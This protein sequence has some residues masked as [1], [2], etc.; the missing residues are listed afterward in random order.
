MLFVVIPACS[1]PQYQSINMIHMPDESWIPDSVLSCATSLQANCTN[2]YL[3]H[4][5]SIPPH[6]KVV[7]N[8]HKHNSI[9][10][11]QISV[12]LRDLK[13]LGRNT[14]NQYC[15]QKVSTSRPTA[16]SRAIGLS[17][18][19]LVSQHL[20]SWKIHNAVVDKRRPTSPKLPRYER[21][22][23]CTVAGSI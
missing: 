14:D 19:I 2:R 16:L 3:Q 5:V 9:D 21:I 18:V 8:W 17:W 13:S 1:Q 11:H 10:L 15:N 23:F 6:T 20:S 12:K 22:L 4:S 7:C